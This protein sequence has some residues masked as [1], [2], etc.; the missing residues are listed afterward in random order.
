MICGQGEHTPQKWT[1]YYKM[2]TKSRFLHLITGP[3]LYQSII[4]VAKSGK[5]NVNACKGGKSLVIQ[6]TTGL[7]SRAKNA[8]AINVLKSKLESQEFQ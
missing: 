5:M 8:I 4:F 3:K 6:I 1:W 7:V 2:N